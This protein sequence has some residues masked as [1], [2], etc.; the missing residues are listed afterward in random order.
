MQ[1]MGHPLTQF[2][3]PLPAVTLER[4]CD[5]FSITTAEELVSASANCA[6][7]LRI[8]LD[9]TRHGWDDMV[10]LAYNSVEPSIRDFLLAP[11]ASP[12]GKGAVL[13]KNENL[14]GDYSRYLR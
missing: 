13:C 10:R 12:F 4:L 11:F 3:I 9:F 14:P 2:A 8:A 5:E 1:K 6:A 7:H